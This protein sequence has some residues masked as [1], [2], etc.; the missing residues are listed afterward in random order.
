MKR[1]LC[2]KF[3]EQHKLT[4]NL[5]TL[6]KRFTND[7]WIVRKRKEGKSR[8]DI[9][10][11]WAIALIGVER[12]KEISNMKNLSFVFIALIAVLGCGNGGGTTSPSNLV[13]QSISPSS[14][15]PSTAGPIVNIPKLIGKPPGEFEKVY[16]NATEISETNDPGTTPGDIRDYSVPGVSD[17]NSTEHGL[18]VRFHKGK[19]V[20]ML[21]DFPKP[22]DDR[23]SAFA[24]VGLDIKGKAPH[25]TAPLSEGWEHY[26]INDIFFKRA[27]A[28]KLGSDKRFT[29]FKCEI[30]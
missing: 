24:L 19:A 13:N 28:M 15:P 18:M 5:C 3:E 20:S 21:V 17:P 27:E 6:Q 22:V 2:F 11:H 16:G 4:P 25:F 7:Q 23:E 12:S 30:E 9:P 29:S 10:I 1:R 8:Y 14:T 26:L